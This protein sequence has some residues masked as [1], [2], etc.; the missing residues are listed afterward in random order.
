MH[1][2]D[3]LLIGNPLISSYITLVLKQFIYKR[4]KMVNRD[5]GQTSCNLRRCL[6]LQKVAC[7]PFSAE[8]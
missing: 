6:Y 7:P 4:E 2:L 8:A 3:N 1:F 5:I